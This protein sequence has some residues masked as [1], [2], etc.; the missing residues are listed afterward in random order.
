MLELIDEED[1][2]ASSVDYYQLENVPV[3]E[4]IHGKGLISLG[5]FDAIDE[6]FAGKDLRQ[7]KLL[8]IGFGIGGIPYYLAGEHGANVCGLEV[9]DWMVAYAEQSTPKELL[10]RVKFLT[11]DRNGN[12]PLPN[13][14]ID[15]V[16]SKGVLAYIENKESLFGE[17][18]RVLRPEGT[19]CLI[20]WLAPPI[21][22]KVS[23]RLL[24]GETLHKETVQ[25]YE[26]IL[27]VCGFSCIEFHDYNQSY[28]TYVRDLL[29]RLKDLAHIE[30]YGNVLSDDLREDII[31]T[32]TKTAQK[33]EN[34]TQISYR[35]L[36]KYTNL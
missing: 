31:E 21:K 12:I 32:Y 23:E 14:S 36:A 13:G 6:M 25:S 3:F 9:K 34:R 29:A 1:N 5:G 35:I 22:G 17:I 28:L 20:D 24:H 26:E 10:D 27:K 7:Q 8:D 33:I 15:L 30:Q 11:Y 4:A 16:Y 2:V 19:I 18:A